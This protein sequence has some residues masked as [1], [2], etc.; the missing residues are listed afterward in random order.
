MKKA[1]KTPNN[2][3]KRGMIQVPL[4]TS[5]I[6]R[7]AVADGTLGRDKQGTGFTFEYAP[8]GNMDVA[9]RMRIFPACVFFFPCGV[10]LLEVCEIWT[11]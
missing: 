6:W 5:A 7:A 4:I 10:T 3:E 9:I 8:F 11:P 1:A 2:S